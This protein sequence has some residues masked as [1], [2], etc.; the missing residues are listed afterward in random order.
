MKNKEMR[1]FM[2]SVFLHETQIRL[3]VFN[4]AKYTT[5]VWRYLYRTIHE[6]TELSAGNVRTKE[7]FR[8]Q[9]CIHF[10]FNKDIP[11]QFADG[12]YSD[13]HNSNKKHLIS[14]YGT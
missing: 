5:T 7:S 13:V 4:P 8:K 14:V 3:E 12:I 10:W 9:H 11:I 2:I 1:F 6:L